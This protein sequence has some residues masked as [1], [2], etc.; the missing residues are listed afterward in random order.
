MPGPVHIRDPRGSAD[1]RD[2]AAGDRDDR[3]AQRDV[4]SVD[5]DSAARVRDDR[6]RT[7][8]VEADLHRRDVLFRLRRL[9]NRLAAPC[10]EGPAA[11]RPGD[12]GSGPA[13]AALLPTAEEADAV[14]SLLDDAIAL[15]EDG[16]VAQSHSARDRRDA[17]RDRVAAAADRGAA[18]RDRDDSAADRQQA[19][20]DRE[21]TDHRIDFDAVGPRA[22]SGEDTTRASVDEVCAASRDRIAES[23]RI[24]DR[25]GRR[26]ARPGRPGDLT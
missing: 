16:D 7:R 18:A 9:R 5:R 23:E 20:I 14:R 24:L 1:L 21:Q 6:A 3:A 4:G 26:T 25:R 15:L 2:D 17:A 22:G 10:A 11:G 12:D 8:E 13:A 19:C